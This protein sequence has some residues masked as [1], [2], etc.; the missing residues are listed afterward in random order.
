MGWE[1]FG[2]NLLSKKRRR[3]EMG[4]KEP[5][6]REGGSEAYRRLRKEFAKRDK[7]KK[8]EDE[9]YKKHNESVRKGKYADGGTKFKKL[10]E[11]LRKKK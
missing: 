6:E 3:K 4:Q 5:Y 7:K 11:L 1:S 10:K 9:F 8:E 2:K